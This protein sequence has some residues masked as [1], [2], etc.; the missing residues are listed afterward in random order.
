MYFP[1]VSTTKAITN[2]PQT[3]KINPAWYIFLTFIFPVPY[4]MVLGAVATGSINP[5]DAAKVAGTMSIIGF[6]L[7]ATL[8]GSIT[9]SMSWMLATLDENSL[10]KVMIRHKEMTIG[11]N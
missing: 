7:R 5:S 3:F 6:I 11:N 4:T 10:N 8:N 9:G 2:T 1:K